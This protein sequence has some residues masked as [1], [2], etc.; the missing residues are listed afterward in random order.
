MGEYDHV[1]GLEFCW[2][3]PKSRPIAGGIN[4]LLGVLCFV[5]LM[6]HTLYDMYKAF[7]TC[8][9]ALIGRELMHILMLTIYCFP[10]FALL[11]L[12]MTSDLIWEN[13]TS[14]A[15]GSAYSYFA[16]TTY[17]Y[18]VLTGLF[19]SSIGL[20]LAVLFAF[21]L[22]TYYGYGTDTRRTNPD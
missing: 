16:L 20:S 21:R 3:G 7:K 9:D 19:L 13:W 22:V 18:C 10:S 5:I 4:I 2:L 8:R 12:F 1:L 17:S 11:L 15:V 14:V 6:P